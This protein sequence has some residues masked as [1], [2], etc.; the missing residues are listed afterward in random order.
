MQGYNSFW[1][2]KVI[3]KIRVRERENIYRIYINAQPIHNI[4]H[5][6]QLVQ[7][8]KGKK[9]KKLKEIQG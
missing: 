4:Q 5:N 6:P 1:K 9:L 2:S 7:N 8:I 3:I